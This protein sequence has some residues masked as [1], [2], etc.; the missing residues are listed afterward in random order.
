MALALRNKIGLLE[1]NRGSWT[2]GTAVSHVPPL[3]WA[4]AGP[5]AQD[6]SQPPVGQ[7]GRD[8]GGSVR[9]Q[10]DPGAGDRQVAP[11]HKRDLDRQIL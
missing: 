9:G 6:G 2:P 8:L 7:S 3:L 11:E 4:G 5:G 10:V 1:E